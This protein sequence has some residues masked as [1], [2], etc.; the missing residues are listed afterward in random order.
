M[1]EMPALVLFVE[2]ASYWEIDR[3]DADLQ[4][5]EIWMKFQEQSRRYTILHT[6]VFKNLSTFEFFANYSQ[7]IWQLETYTGHV[8]MCRL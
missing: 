2:T 8:S 6:L 3:P 7:P 1:A 5:E 4:E